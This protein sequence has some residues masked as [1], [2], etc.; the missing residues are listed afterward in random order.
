[1]KNG[2]YGA[3]HTQ[4]GILTLELHYKKVPATVGNFVGLAE[5]SLA[6]EVKQTGI[7][8][9]DGLNFHRVIPDFMIQEVVSRE[10]VSGRLP[11][12]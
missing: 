4:K 3:I 7:P 10:W 12:W 11:I 8:Y 9:Y 1:M 6:N 5:G 2:I